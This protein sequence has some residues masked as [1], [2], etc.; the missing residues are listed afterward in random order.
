VADRGN[1]Q[2]VKNIVTQLEAQGRDEKNLHRKVARP[3]GWYDSVDEGERFKVKRIQVKPGAS[4]SLQMHHHRAEHWIVVKGV[5]EITNG[6]QIITLKENQSTYI[7]QGQ[8]HRLA[9]LG[10]EPLEIIE[11]QSGSYLGEDDIVR[12]EDTYGRS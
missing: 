3:W 5:A 9:N 4:L 12:F 6:D 1:S 8:T 7:P 11:V 10:T 2:D